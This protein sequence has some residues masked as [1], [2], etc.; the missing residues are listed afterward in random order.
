[1]IRVIRALALFVPTALLAASGSISRTFE[2]APGDFVFGKA[3]GF[4][5]VS[6][7]NQYSTSQPGSPSLPLA[8]YNIV[9]PPDAEVTGVEVVSAAEV[10]LPGEF[11]IHPA[12]RPYVL[13]KPAPALLPPD[14]VAYS[15]AK[16]YPAGIV[17]FT[18]S[19]QLGGFRIAGLQ[20]TPLRYVAARHELLLATRLV[21]SVRY[22]LNRH[23][24]T[25]LERGQ[26]VLLGNYAR[27]LVTNLDDLARF[28]PP[29]RQLDD[30]LCDMMV[31]TSSAMVPSFQPFADWKTRRGIKTVI[32]RTESIYST[33]PGRDNPE[34][35]RNCI[36]DYW[37]NHGLK[38]VLVGGDDGIVPVR[39]ARLTVEGNVEDIATDM[40]YADLQYSWDSDHNDLFGEM[41]DSVDF[42]Y[43]VFVG[44]AP[45]DNA[46][47]AQNFFAKCTTYER[48]PDSSYIKKVLYGSTMLF[49]PY[50]G[51]VP[52]HLIAELFPAGWTHAHLEDPPYG[53]YADSMSAGFQLAHVA[54]HGNPSTF[55]V[56]DQS[57]VPGLTNGLRKLN[58]VNS[59]AC[60]AGWFDGQ[61][62]LA[63]DL[64]N[65]TT[66]G[67]IALMLNSRYGFGYP[68]GL[69]PSEMLDIQFYRYF[70]NGD[71]S[72]YGVLGAMCKDYFQS[73]SMGQEVWRWCVYELNLMGDPT[74]HVWSE[75]PRVLVVQRAD[76]ALVG[77]QVF[78]VTVKDGSTPVPGALACLSKGSETYARGWTN[79][80]G[81]VDLF[82][83]PT[84]AGNLGLSASAQNYY[85]YEGQVPV[86]GSTSGPALTF[87]GLRID[88]GGNGRLDP[89]ET[90][91][92]FVSLTNS[93]ASA[94]TGVTA[95]L[96]TACPY[97]ALADSTAAYGTIAPGA[98]VEGDAFVV[99]ASAATPPGS[100]AELI[101]ACTADQG[102]WEPYTESRIGDLPSAHK[103][104]ADHD[105]GNMILSVTTV[106]SIGTLG[107]YREG[108]GLKYP[109]TA[110][111]GSLYFTSL[112]CGNG[113]NYVV[114]RWYGHPTSTFQTDWRAVDT[115]HAVIPP[116]AADEEY[117]A[118]ID[119]G[120]HPTPKGLTVTQWSGAMAADGYNDF[121]IIQYALGNAGAQPIDGL[122][123]GI[124]SDFDIDNT[125]D[126][127]VTTDAGRRYIYMTQSE[128][129]ENSAGIK[130]LSPAAAANLS[131]IDHAVYVTPG[132]M[133]TEAVKDSFLRGLIVRPNSSRTDN[134]S[135]VASAGPFNLDPGAR[136]YVAF[137]MVGGNSQAEMLEH[138]DS[139][140]SWYDHRMTTDL[141]ASAGTVLERPGIVVS[142]SPVTRS[143][144]VRFSV[145]ADGI[146]R[147]AVYDA[148]GRV[149]RV[150]AAGLRRGVHVTSWDCTDARG[151]A[152]PNGVYLFRFETPSGTVDRKAIVVR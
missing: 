12:Q 88:D 59:M 109:R 63:E 124:F 69:G 123:C 55:S 40:Y 42:F 152:V 53:A 48:H 30:W 72:Q 80:Q 89:G 71:A 142:P 145:P 23:E 54:A 46:A 3:N 31:I 130:L 107:P 126:N 18:R 134:W 58:F 66:G 21:V 47:Q 151:R 75:K 138:A 26:L 39:T 93:G 5:V 7:P 119:D 67:C 117:Q 113:P 64:M 6:L 112:A 13:S 100:L 148:S 91:S 25:P 2:F 131:A 22:E 61:E 36:T 34:R 20:V 111:Y 65:C 52:N 28:A 115:L 150:L 102:S 38:W 60:E 118:V 98:T 8:C 33:Y 122:Y 79:S 85:P 84:T 35:I 37:R 116:I 95:K 105:T 82:V 141:T 14:A 77:P 125:T 99:A 78:R 97:L 132:S 70:V 51:R 4:D 27:G 29:V 108:S 133:L 43:D 128:S 101:A 127:N 139:A 11:V 50:H 41:T 49:D 144:M 86:R 110:G 90:A 103:L 32:V 106:G 57:E 9:I 104:F 81:W 140:Q 1:M 74:L 147:L 87:A 143:A 44:R 146:G 17:Q 120:A 68:P 76:S 96:R 121:V 10:V 135:C 114:D 62:C 92:L 19:G 16:P 137:A 73:L 15:S 149:V 94:A 24:V 56:M 129:E 83:Q 45:V 136:Q